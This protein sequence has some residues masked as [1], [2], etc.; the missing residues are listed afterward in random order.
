M[1]GDKVWTRASELFEQVLDVPEPDRAA[2]LAERTADD[3]EVLREVESMLDA[4]RRADGILERPI[5]VDAD[6]V[7]D[8]LQTA[9]AGEYEIVRELGRGGM[10]LVFLAW[11]RKHD[12][13]VVLKVLR[14]EVAFAYGN[15]RF[16]REVRFA[17]QLSHPHILGLID[18][19]VAEGLV[20]YVMPHVE[21]ETLKDRIEDTGPLPIRQAL[22]LLTDIARALAYAHEAGVVHRDLKPDNVLCAGS[23]AFLMDFGIAK[24]LAPETGAEALTMTGLVIGTPRYMAPE[25]LQAVG[26]IDHRVDIYAWGLL[27]YEML[28]GE[29]LPASTSRL[30]SG[31]SRTV[32]DTIRRERPRV[33]TELARAIGRC[34][35][36]DPEARCQTADEILESLDA[37]ASPVNRRRRFRVRAGWAYAAVAALL[38]VVALVVGT[39]DRADSVAGVPSVPTPVAV[40]SFSNE[41]GDE[42]LSALGRLAGDWLTQGLQQTG[43]VSVVPWPTARLASDRAFAA[44]QEDPTLDLVRFIHEETGAGSVITG[45]FYLVGDQLQFQ[46]EV[47]DPVAGTILSAP[48]P[49]SVPRDSAEA[50]IRSLRNRLMGSMAVTSDDRT[51]AMP[52]LAQHPPTYEAYRAFDR[53]LEQYL[54]QQYSRAIPDFYR[55]FELDSTF[56]VS[57]LYA[58]VALYNRGEYSQ[59]DSLLTEL[60]PHRERLNEYYD[61]RYQYLQALLANDGRRAL[62]VT[63]RAAEIAPLTKASYNYAYTAILMNRPREALAHLEA[64]DPDRGSMRG[65]ASYWTQLTHAYHLVGDHESEVTAAREMMARHPERR[66]APVLVV[67]ALAAVGDTAGVDA[68][69]EQIAVLPPTTYWSQGAAMVV[70]GEELSAHGDPDLGQTYLD[71]GI[72]W[73]EDKLLVDPDYRQ[74]RYWLGSALYDS[75]R[76]AEAAVLFN[77]LNE[78]YSD[79]RTYRLMEA[80]AVARLGDREAAFEILGERPRYRAGTWTADRARIEAILGERDRAVSLLSDALD[81]GIDS[82]PW[83]HAAGFQDLALLA[84]DP[85]FDRLMEDASSP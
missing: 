35:D 63:A 59:V 41:T 25:Q 61:L 11:E 18:S 24:T 54:L 34:V 60:E 81:Q 78:A 19:G 76:W 22:T 66:V 42:S 21:G 43:L 73:L 80:L 7:S 28:T 40:A 68:F 84:G 20:Y 57:L 51:A 71:R 65:W 55:A 67:R 44:R 53:G 48:D 29:P 3:P 26:E 5:H 37:V 47:M 62:Q 8:F 50:A 45:S 38:A 17:G 32:S 70:V 1:T 12:R 64:L 69:L 75:G 52:G 77:A 27:A 9:L 10:A 46:A 85:R 16:L 2:W 4:H 74:H 6:D 13:R 72:A 30:S 36:P 33:S 56:V 23:H 83:L 79:L 39:R 14:P 15:E 49:V 31:I 82:F 58:A